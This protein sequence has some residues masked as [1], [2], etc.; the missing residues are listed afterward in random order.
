MSDLAERSN[1]RLE[2]NHCL[3]RFNISNKQNDLGF[4]S[5]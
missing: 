5:F 2:N 4:N 3:I 1:V